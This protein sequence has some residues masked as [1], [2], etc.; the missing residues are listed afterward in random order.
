MN[1]K[2]INEDFD[3][4]YEKYKNSPEYK[5]H[6]KDIG[7][8]DFVKIK[9]PTYYIAKHS[10]EDLRA[11]VLAEREACAEIARFARMHS[12]S[13]AIMKRGRNM[14]TKPENIDTSAERV[15][16]TDKSVHEPVTTIET[17]CA[18]LRQAHDVLSMSS[19]PPKREWVGLTDKEI[20]LVLDK[21][22]WASGYASWGQFAKDIEAKLK[23]RNT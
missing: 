8:K 5:K 22:T 6:I 18:L 13:D 7:E 21:N 19:L 12:I 20:S 9:M 23:E 10:D 3:R 2:E 4:E 14:S 11:A 15:H 1:M 17:A 16:E